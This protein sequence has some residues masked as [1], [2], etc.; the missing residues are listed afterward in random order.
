MPNKYLPGL[1]EDDRM[2]Y[3]EERLITLG[4]LAG[5]LIVIARSPRDEGKRIISPEKGEPT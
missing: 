1:A 5:R 4:L 2:D 3:G